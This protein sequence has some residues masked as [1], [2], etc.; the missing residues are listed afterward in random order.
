[1]PRWWNTLTHICQAAIHQAAQ[2]IERESS[3]LVEILGMSPETQTVTRLNEFEEGGDSSESDRKDIVYLNCSLEFAR[4]SVRANMEPVRAAF[5][6]TM[7]P[8]LF[9]PSPRKVMQRAGVDHVKY[10]C[11]QSVRSLPRT[12]EMCDACVAWSPHALTP[13][14]SKPRCQVQAR[15]KPSRFSAD[16]DLHLPINS[17]WLSVLDWRHLRRTSVEEAATSPGLVRFGTFEVDLRAGEL[18][19]A[20][21]K[22]KLTGQPFQVLAILLE[23]PGEVVTR[24]ELQKRL[25]PDTFVD[26]DHNLNT[27]INKIREVLGDS[28]ESPRFVETLTSAGLPVHRGRDWGGPCARTA[29]RPTKLPLRPQTDGERRFANRSYEGAGYSA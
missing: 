29:R 15:H 24:E 12:Q 10:V 2:Q 7:P 9:F 16:S 4:S 26:V 22:L 8:L 20:G 17:L 5:L 21:V 13:V 25:W 14:Q 11:L 1:M 28:A 23:R 18:R 27:A 19:K 6:S 3:D